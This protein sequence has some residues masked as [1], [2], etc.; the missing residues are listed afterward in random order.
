MTGR[1]FGSSVALFAAGALV[2]NR[3]DAHLLTDADQQ[4]N[5][6]N[7]LS[8]PLQSTSFPCTWLRLAANDYLPT[9]ALEQLKR[10]REDLTMVSEP[11]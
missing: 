5:E 2:H 6:V 8:M 10:A 1:S 7:C 9:N 3:R 11:M 4:E